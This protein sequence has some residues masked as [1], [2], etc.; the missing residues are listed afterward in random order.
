MHSGGRN[1]LTL[2]SRISQSR[3]ATAAAVGRSRQSD[4]RIFSISIGMPM[5]T[6]RR[7]EATSVSAAVQRRRSERSRSKL[8]SSTTKRPE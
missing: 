4:F 7:R 6:A 1:G 5:L 3:A 8:G 2:R